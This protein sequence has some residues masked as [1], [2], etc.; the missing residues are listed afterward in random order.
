MNSIALTFSAR[1]PKTLALGKCR[2]RHSA[3]RKE[4]SSAWFSFA[5]M[6]LFCEKGARELPDITQPPGRFSMAATYEN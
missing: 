4:R 1:S 5:T 3:G 2:W 6:V